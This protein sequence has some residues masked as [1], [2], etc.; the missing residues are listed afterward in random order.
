MKVKEIEFGVTVSLGALESSKL[1]IRVEIEEGEDYDQTLARLKEEVVRTSGATEAGK[2]TLLRRI[3]QADGNQELL[4]T[5]EK[6]D[7]VNRLLQSKKEDLE[8]KLYQLGQVEDKVHEVSSLLESF[9][10]VLGNCSLNEAHK[11]IKAYNEI[12]ANQD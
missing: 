3:A 1:S 9:T 11:I 8:Y 2:A 7:E 10:S 12:Q 4:K 5:A 6:I